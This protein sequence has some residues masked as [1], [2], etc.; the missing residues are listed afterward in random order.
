MDSAKD[1]LRQK[2]SR[3][4]TLPGLERSLQNEPKDSTP[5][6]EKH[7]QAASTPQQIQ[8]PPEADVIEFRKLRIDR[9][10][11]DRVEEDLRQEKSLN[12]DVLF[13]AMYTVCRQD[14]ELWQRVKDEAMRR[15]NLRRKAARIKSAQTRLSNL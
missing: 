11:C 9:H 6:Q 8:I 7:Q 5:V 2:V 4:N 13:E 1:F 10:T 14:P 12:Q 3:R 15:K